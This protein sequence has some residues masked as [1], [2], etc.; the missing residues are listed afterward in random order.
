VKKMSRKQNSPGHFEFPISAHL[1]PYGTS[2]YLATFSPN[3]KTTGPTFWPPWWPTDKLFNF[4]HYNEALNKFINFPP[5]LRLTYRAY[6]P[7]TSKQSQY[8]WLVLRRPK[9]LRTR[10]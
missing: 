4:L 8:V 7:Q 6:Q 2:L 1:P 5:R 9:C 10:R 3:I